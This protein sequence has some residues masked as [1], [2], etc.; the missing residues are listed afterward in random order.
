VLRKQAADVQSVT[1]DRRRALLQ[2]AQTAARRAVRDGWLCPNDLPHA[3]R[4]LA[5]VAAMRGAVRR[6]RKLLNRSL[7]IARR[8][9]AR[10]E[11][12]QTLLVRAQLGQEK[13]WA[14]ADEDRREAQAVLAQLQASQQEQ[15]PSEP[16]EATLSLAD[17]FDG[18][19]HWGRRIA[20]ALSPTAIY[21]EARLAAL[22]LLRAEHCVVLQVEMNYDPPRF[23]ALLGA[24]PGDWNDDRLRE[25]IAAKQALAF[26]EESPHGRDRLQGGERSALC[27][28]IYARG[29]LT[30]CLYATHEHI[31]ALFGSVEERLADY[32]ATTA[33]AALENAEGFT[34]LQALNQTLEARVAERTKAAEWRACEL[35]ASNQQL[36]RLTVELQAAQ[37]ESMLARQVAEAASD[38]KSRFLATMSHEIRT[39]LNGVIGMTEL[40]M[41]TPLSPQQRNYVATA[42]ESANSL[43][44][45][46]NDVLDFSKIEAGRMELESIPFNI[47]EVVEDAARVLSATAARKG[48]ELICHCDATVPSRVLGD[49]NRLRQILINLIGNAIKFTAQ[50]EVCVRVDRSRTGDRDRLQFAVQDTG[51]GIPADKH[52]SIFEPFR[53]SDGSMTRRFGGT[54]LGLSITSQLV[55]LMGGSIQVESEPGVG[56]KFRFDIPLTLAEPGTVDSP[57]SISGLPRPAR[58]LFWSNNTNQKEACKSLLA[59]LGLHVD[60]LPDNPNTAQIDFG[61]NPDTQLVIDVPVAGKLPF[62][63]DQ[64]R[65]RLGLAPS[66]VVVLAPAGQ[67]DVIDACNALGLTRCITKP[68]RA[69]ELAALFSHAVVADAK[70]IAPSP[71]PA[72]RSLR[73]LVADDS[74]VNQEVAAGLLQLAGH[75]VVTVATGSEAVEAWKQERF[76]AIFMDL[77]MPEMDGFEATACIRRQEAAN[78]KMTP[79]IALTAHALKGVHERCTQAGMDH[80][81][82]KPLQPEELMSLLASLAHVSEGG[83]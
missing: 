32:I 22:R 27:V 19:L 25:A 37:R 9:A 35:A 30:A 1:P 44:S 16:V 28:P 18:V 62:D 26:L 55:S 20:L 67:T 66:Q 69:R 77:E 58:A 57:T 50:G 36:E 82:T 39:P 83:D 6:S 73:L 10:Y 54:G 61:C 40:A 74:P 12:A 70:P 13:G 38:A 17:R 60:A 5:W 42:K 8:H 76:D 59:Y 49:P 34:Q 48:L 43:L 2:R 80:C 29:E 64:L 68:P 4:E 75:T 52:A 63:L 47:R 79:I 72:H 3:L 51:I 23:T 33:G 56:S 78:G 31:H 15:D 21:E 11:I 65:R 53:Q 7:K 81:L 45:L 71:A 46:L 24:I 14:T 41:S